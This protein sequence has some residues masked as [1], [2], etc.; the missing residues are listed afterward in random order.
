MHER[1]A[2]RDGAANAVAQVIARIPPIGVDA[3]LTD[4]SFSEL[5]MWRSG[6]RSVERTKNEGQKGGAFFR[7]KQ[8]SGQLLTQTEG[9]EALD[10]P[11]ARL[12][13]HRGPDRLGTQA[14][15]V[16]DV[17]ARDGEL[18]GMLH[19]A[20]EHILA[21]VG[22][23]QD[24]RTTWQCRQVERRCCRGCRQLFGN[25]RQHIYAP[26]LTPEYDRIAPVRLGETEHPRATD[27]R[28]R[29]HVD[30][31]FA[32]QSIGLLARGEQF[33]LEC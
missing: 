23:K 13:K 4:Q 8:A 32:R 9:I 3:P 1:A 19:I 25:D 14:N 27:R 31:G 12:R 5:A 20:K 24:C 30:K 6:E 17:R 28:R 33:T 26:A 7:R 2:T 15:W 18:E 22:R 10:R 21:L 29:D 16:Q 11:Q